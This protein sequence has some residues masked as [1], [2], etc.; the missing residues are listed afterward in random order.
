MILY[1]SQTSPF[2]RRLRLLL[3]ENTYEFKKVDIFNPDQ[4]Q[5]FLKISPLL[6]IPVMEIEGHAV[7]D[8]RVIFNVLCQKGFHRLVNLNEENLLTAMD[9]VSDSLVQT[10]LAQRSQVQFP[11]GS[12]LDVSHRERIIHTLEFLASRLV[13]GDFRDWNYLSMC[14][15]TLLDWIEF[16][17][18]A[19]WRQHQALV[20][21]W[22]TNRSRPRVEETDPRRS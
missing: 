22:E 4:R 16:R 14:L 2:V 15:Y 8:S 20:N 17:Q 5:Q 6:K 9:D 7:W 13:A 12:P 19:D 18:L 3:A 11:Q 1:G 10:L 21:F